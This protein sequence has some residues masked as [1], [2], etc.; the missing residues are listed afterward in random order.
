MGT[1]TGSSAPLFEQDR[2]QVL[3]SEERQQ[4]EATND[5]HRI[6]VAPCA[7][8]PKRAEVEE[9][10]E[11]VQVQATAATLDRGVPRAFFTK[12]FIL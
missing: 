7:E 11:D 1:P 4:E 10:S 3:G 5:G 8:D 6:A 2:R 12:R 9:S